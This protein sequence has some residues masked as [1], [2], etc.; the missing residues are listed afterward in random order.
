MTLW[1]VRTHWPCDA[2]SHSRRSETSKTPLWEPQISQIT[3]LLELSRNRLF[4]LPM[5]SIK[6]NVSMEQC[7]G[8]IQRRS[9]LLRLYK[10]WQQ[11]C[12]M[13]VWNFGGMVPTE[14]KPPSNRWQPCPSASL[15][16]TNLTWAGPRSNPCLRVERPMINTRAKTRLDFL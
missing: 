10:S 13:W 4:V 8:F 9:Q 15:S 14:K 7:W 16:T 5:G 2:G 11:M 3:A 12:E 6:I 1:N